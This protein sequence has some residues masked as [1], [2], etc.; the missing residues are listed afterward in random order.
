MKKRRVL[1]VEWSKRERAWVVRGLPYGLGWFLVKQEAVSWAA[2]NCR[3]HL[4]AGTTSQLKIR[5]KNGRIQSE[6]TYGADPRRHR[7]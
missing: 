2:A 3:H 4:A 6:R 7:G 1:W 5:G